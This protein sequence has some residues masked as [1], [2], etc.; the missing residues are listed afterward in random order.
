MKKYIVL[1]LIMI[2]SFGGCS[3]MTSPAI[4]VDNGIKKVAWHFSI[5]EDVKVA[6]FGDRAEDVKDVFRDFGF[7]VVADQQK[8]LANYIIVVR[9]ENL[10]YG[11]SWGYYIYPAMTKLNVVDDETGIERSYRGT[12]EFRVFVRNYGGINSTY[13]QPSDPYGLAAKMAAAE[14][15]GNF[16]QGNNIL[17]KDLGTRYSPCPEAESIPWDELLSS[18]L[19]LFS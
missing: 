8:E 4:R 12:A 14:A 5:T 2:F 16:I 10:G 3:F 1:L 18:S 15:I 7:K 9:V 11:Y 19:F 6:V 13:H 17:H